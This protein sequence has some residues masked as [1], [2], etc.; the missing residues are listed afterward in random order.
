MIATTKAMKYLDSGFYRISDKLA[1]SLAKA[2]PNPNYQNL[3]PHG[4]ERRITY[5]GYHWW[6]T[7]TPHSPD[8]GG[9]KRGWVYAIYAPRPLATTAH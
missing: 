3:P 5:N 8:F 4:Y 9:P 1:A 2:H 6:L 7:R